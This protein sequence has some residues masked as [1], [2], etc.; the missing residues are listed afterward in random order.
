MAEKLPAET[1]PENKEP[2]KRKHPIDQYIHRGSR[3]GFR[4]ISRKKKGS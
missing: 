4:Q 1:A 2:K 3:E